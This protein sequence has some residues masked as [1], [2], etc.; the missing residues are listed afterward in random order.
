[1]EVGQVVVPMEV[2]RD[3]SRSRDTC[4]KQ[5][6]P[7]QSVGFCTTTP[8]KE[9]AA[10]RLNAEDGASS[11]VTLDVCVDG[12]NTE[13]ENMG[14][15]NA[16]QPVVPLT[17]MRM[18]GTPLVELHDVDLMQSVGDMKVRIAQV[19]NT[20]PAHIGLVLGDRDLADDGRSLADE[21]VNAGDVLTF[22]RL[23]PTNASL[24]YIEEDDPLLVHFLHDCGADLCEQDEIGWT[25]LHW[26]AYRRFSSVGAALL[27]HENF[28]AINARDMGKMTAFHVCAQHGVLKL[29]EAIARHIDFNALNARSANGHTAL[30]WAAQNAHLAMCEFI[31]SLP[32]FTALNDQN[33]HGWTVLHYAAALGLPSIAESLLQN[34]AFVAVG[35]L[36]NNGETA[37]HWA[38]LNGHLDICK[39]LAI[40]SE[41]DVA[42]QDLDGLT[43]WDGAN[44]NRHI[45]VCELLA[46]LKPNRQPCLEKKPLA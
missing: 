43:A 7:S 4:R 41:I 5:S 44:T 12:C 9:I 6:F 29:G 13:G 1:M 38:A 37:L 31:L 26:A 45:A 15:G 39:S 24:L 14:G 27:E 8:V 19:S 34:E 30:H 17:I 18:S 32:G 36:T 11:A 40:R 46:S 23:A 21:G 16:S 42:L 28:V 2:R 33:M 3:R 10:G 20:P 35:E 22:V 25:A